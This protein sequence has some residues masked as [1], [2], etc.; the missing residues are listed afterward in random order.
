VHAFPGFPNVFG[1]EFKS[2]NSIHD[3]LAST[4]LTILSNQHLSLSTEI[5]FLMFGRLHASYVD[6]PHPYSKY[7]DERSK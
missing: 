5:T 6:P 7:T 3:L 4:D 2:E 1:R